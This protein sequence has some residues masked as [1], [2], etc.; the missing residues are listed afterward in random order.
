[1]IIICQC[2]RLEDHFCM[3]VNIIN[4]TSTTPP[5]ML[6][7]RDSSSWRPAP[8]SRMTRLPRLFLPS[9]RSRRMWLEILP[10]PCTTSPS[11]LSGRNLLNNFVTSKSLR[12]SNTPKIISWFRLS[13]DDESEDEGVSID[14][15]K[16]ALE[17]L[18]DVSGANKVYD[19]SKSFV[20][21]AGVSSEPDSE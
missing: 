21:E 18:V 13:S 11:D 5:A 3:K 20:D 2:S 15:V 8:P 9:S 12:C 6:G 4:S 19:I 16:K 17:R 7:A 10:S 14:D 1:M